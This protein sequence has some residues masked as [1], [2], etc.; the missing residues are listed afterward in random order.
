MTS[1]RNLLVSFLAVTIATAALAGIA[2]GPDPSGPPSPA[3]AKSTW[4]W[5][6]ID[7][8]EPSIDGLSRK[9]VQIKWPETSFEF[10]RWHELHARELRRRG[11]IAWD[12]HPAHESRF[13]WLS[14]CLDR[15]PNYWRNVDEATAM[16]VAHQGHLAE[17]DLPARRDWELHYLVY[18]A[19]SIRPG[20]SSGESRYWSMR[21]RELCVA[22]ADAD[23]LQ[24]SGQV[25]DLL[26]IANGLVDFAFT[27]PEALRGW[28]A[29]LGPWLMSVAGQQVAV[30]RGLIEALKLSPDVSVKE[31]ALGW[32]RVQELREKP[33]ALELPTFDGGRL[34]LESLRGKTVL[35]DIWSNYCSACIRE[36][37]N[38]QRALNLNQAN[39]FEVVGLWMAKAGKDPD[40][41]LAKARKLSD[42]AGAR[43]TN[44]ILSGEE[45]IEFQKRY[46]MQGMPVHWLLGPDGRLISNELYIGKALEEKLKKV[47]PRADSPKAP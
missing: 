47:M 19:D 4:D 34:N 8:D 7:F 38:I 23:R 33:L 3:D 20:S 21:Y 6:Y 26:P 18:K 22:L 31:A 42:G 41:E 30:T 11:M 35:I 45:S 36:I 29:S 5:A 28:A 46:G 16:A 25:A 44:V 17:I 32:E 24:K 37:P 40:A 13:Y 10:I 9:A 1:L 43:W 12:L 15:I 14:I 27:A 39:G 2:A